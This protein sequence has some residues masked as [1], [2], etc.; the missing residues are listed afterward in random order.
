LNVIK[1]IPNLL[2]FPYSYALKVYGDEPYID[3]FQYLI[4]LGLLI[5]I[6]NFYLGKFFIKRLI[7][8]QN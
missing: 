2:M 4:S 1:Y 3:E 5:I 8:N 7:L 6:L